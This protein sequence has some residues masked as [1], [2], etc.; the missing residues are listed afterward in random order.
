MWK[1]FKEEKPPQDVL[2]L[3]FRAKRRRYA[4]AC[5]I[6]DKEWELDGAPNEWNWLTQHRSAHQVEQ[7]DAWMPFEYY[8]KHTVFD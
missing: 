8:E 1:L 2:L 5:L 6:E 4:V 7:D 3:V